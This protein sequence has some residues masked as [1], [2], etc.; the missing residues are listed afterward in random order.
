MNIDPI[1]KQFIIEK[2]LTVSGLLSAIYL[3]SWRVDKTIWLAELSDNKH[4]GNI[5][6]YTL[7]LFIFFGALLGL[8]IYID[9]ILIN[10]DV[11][12]NQVTI[13]VVN[14]LIF[15]I[16]VLTDLLLW[17]LVIYG[18]IQPKFMQ[19]EPIGIITSLVHH[20]KYAL[21]LAL[22]GAVFCFIASVIV[23]I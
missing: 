6:G 9:N 22:F 14:L 18:R 7:Y 1:L 2:G 23:T 13:L 15:G 3:L 12:F 10:A 8:L 20:L 11:G 4:R 16:H 17:D 21:R 5:K 19:L